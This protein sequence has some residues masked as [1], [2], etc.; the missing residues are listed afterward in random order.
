MWDKWLVDEDSVNALAPTG[1]DDYAARMRVKALGQRLTGA[2]ATYEVQP[3]SPELYQDSTGLAHCRIA[4]KGDSG[5]FAPSLAWILLSHFG[6]LATV[7]DCHDPEL[8]AQIRSVLEDFGLKYIPYDYVANT[9]YN[10]KCGS[11]IGFSWANRY[12]SLAVEFNTETLSDDSDLTQ[13]N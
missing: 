2:L 1:Y 11:L 4:A 9:T 3:G 6:D 13:H 10:G 12:F 7:K 5:P 8:L